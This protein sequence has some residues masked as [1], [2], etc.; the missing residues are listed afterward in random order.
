M[1]TQPQLPIWYHQW[2]Q[3][4]SHHTCM[5][6]FI[7]SE[8][9]RYRNKNELSKYWL[10]GKQ[11]RK[12]W[13]LTNVKLG[14]FYSLVNKGGQYDSSSHCFTLSGGECGEKQSLS[15]RDHKHW[16]LRSVEFMSTKFFFTNILAGTA[17]HPKVKFEWSQTAQSTAY[18]VSRFSK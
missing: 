14:S 18:F 5:I 17:C 8:V 7:L 9:F 2:H 6:P 15:P 10:I 3:V 16:K 1:T 11:K 12:Q 4:E 13:G